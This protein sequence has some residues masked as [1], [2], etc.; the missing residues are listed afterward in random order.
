[1]LKDASTWLPGP[2]ECKFLS[3]ILRSMNVLGSAD[4]LSGAIVNKVILLLSCG[5]ECMNSSGFSFVYN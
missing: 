2:C 5:A 3:G 4:R 1:M